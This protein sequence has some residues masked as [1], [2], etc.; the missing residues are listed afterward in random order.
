MLILAPV[1]H[2]QILQNS[3]LV[4]EMKNF[5]FS[6]KAQSKAKKKIYCIDNGLINATTF[7]FSKNYGKLL[8]N[9][10]Y[11]ELK[12]KHEKNIYFH[13]DQIECDFV[14][15]NEDRIAIQ[16]CYQLNS[17]NRDREIK[18]LVAAMEQ[19]SISN[20]LIITYD[21]EEMIAPNIQILPFWKWSS[22]F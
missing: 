18:G 10:V 19:F 5:S 6:L 13:N 11:S 3:Y 15:Y 17:E 12:K 4:E 16:A 2:I 1:I 14:L 9:L 22:T 7:K 20:G 21:Q 8:E